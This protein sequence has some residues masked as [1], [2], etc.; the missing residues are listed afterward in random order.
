MAMGESETGNLMGSDT[1]EGTAV[2]YARKL[3]CSLR[4]DDLHFMA[5]HFLRQLAFE[6]V[7]E[8]LELKA[9]SGPD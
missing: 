7:A 8:P 2:S 4:W 1:V 6:S 5:A 9:L 3:S